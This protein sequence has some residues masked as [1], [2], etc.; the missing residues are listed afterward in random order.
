MELS[1]IIVNYNVKH[2][3]EQCL[4]S[5]IKAMKGIQG[6]IIVV[7]NNSVDGSID[8]INQ[9]FKDIVLI[10]NKENT[11]FSVA[12]NQ[13]IKIAKGE[14]ILLL[15]PDTVVQEDTFTKCLE[16]LDN[17]Q[18]AGALGVKMY[19]GNGR[20]LPESKRGLPTPGVAFYKIFGLSAIFPQSRIFGKYHLGYLSMNE[21][22][23]VDV[24]SGAYML[25]RKKVLDEVGL[26]DETFLC[27]AKILTF[28]YRIKKRRIRKLLLLQNKDYSL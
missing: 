18:D 4:I 25:I 17:N 27:T 10:S 23:K 15:N 20:F 2:F 19:D 21:N 11:G 13:G 24:L 22:H 9:K 8:L 6:E 28:S 1:V 7:D 5:V 3:L 26:L 12:N 14:N 16:F